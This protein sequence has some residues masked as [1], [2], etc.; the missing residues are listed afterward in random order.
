MQ[1]GKTDET[2]EALRE[3][4]TIMSRSPRIISLSGWSG[5]WVG[6]IALVGAFVAYSLLQL[7]GYKDIGTSLSATPEHFDKYT[8]HIILLGIV[9]FSAALGG[10]IYFNCRKAARHGQGIW[11]DASR[12]ML[13]Q[14]FYPV[15]SGGV[16]CLLFIYHGCGL[17]VAPTCLV[18]YGLALI[19]SSRHI[20]SDIR[21]LGMLDVALGCTAMFFPGFGLVFWA[22]GFGVLHIFYGVMMWS[23]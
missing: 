8:V 12:L 20:L 2:Q 1:Q 14:L 23:K 3:M 10:T 5:I 7:P 17:F 21:Y 19:S 11:N 4:R 13:G 16:F 18:F 9:V 6:T 22:L 15:F